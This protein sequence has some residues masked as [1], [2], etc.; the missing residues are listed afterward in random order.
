MPGMMKER[1]EKSLMAKAKAKGLKG[2]A[3]D[4]YVY[5]TMT[6]IGGS[7]FANKASKMGSVRSS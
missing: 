7:K 1:L 5:G 3:A 6:K 2:K 4:S